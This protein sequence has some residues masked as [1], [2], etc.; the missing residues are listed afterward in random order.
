MLSIVQTVASSFRCHSLGNAACSNQTPHFA[1]WVKL[2]TDCIAVATQA[3]QTWWTR[4][5]NIQH[6]ASLF[7]THE[8]L[9][10]CCYTY[11]WMF[12]HTECFHTLSNAEDVLQKCLALHAMRLDTLSR[13]LYGW[14]LQLCMLVLQCPQQDC[15]ALRSQMQNGDMVN[16]E[17]SQY[18]VVSWQWTNSFSELNLN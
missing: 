2:K 12:L 7:T 3:A 13:M 5:S 15:T 14:W 16:V 8:P 1:N 9:T 4:R 10:D 17:P 11:T 6:H 18:N